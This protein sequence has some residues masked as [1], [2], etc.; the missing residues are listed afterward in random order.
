M[1]RPKRRGRGRPELPADELRTSIL[2]IRFS[3][4]ERAR[5]AEAAYES[6]ARS[7]SDWARSVLLAATRD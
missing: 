3:N 7:A 6:G 1:T 2:A 4:D 5:I